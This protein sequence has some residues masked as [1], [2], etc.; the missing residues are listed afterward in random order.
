[1]HI[2]KFPNKLKNHMHLL[3][4]LFTLL[5]L[6]LIP[7]SS[8]SDEVRVA[9]LIGNNSYTSTPLINAVNDVEAMEKQLNLFEFHVTRATDLSKT[10][11]GKAIIHF[12]QNREPGSIGL[13]YYAGHS[14]VK[15]D[16]TYLAPI[17]VNTTD[18]KSIPHNS[19]PLTY[20]T[21][22]LSQDNNSKNIIIID[23]CR[24]NLDL[25][26]T[27]KNVHKYPLPTQI[28][29]NNIIVFSTSIGA[30]AYDGGNGNSPY[31]KA[32]LSITPHKAE[33]ILQLLKRVNYYVTQI[34]SGEQIPQ[35]YHN[36]QFNFYMKNNFEGTGET[37]NIL[38]AQINRKN[39]SPGLSRGIRIEP[40]PKEIKNTDSSDVIKAEPDKKKI[41][42]PTDKKNPVEKNTSIK[43]E[44]KINPPPEKNEPAKSV[45]SNPVV[46]SINGQRDKM[47]NG[48]LGPVIIEIKTGS[49]KMGG[50]LF[51]E[52]P[53]H[54]V[55]INQPI[56]FMTN[57][58]TFEEYDEFCNATKRNKPDDEFWGRSNR[59]VINV[60]WE[61]AQD[62][63][64]WLSAQT[65]AT[66]RLPLE[67]EWEWAAR[68]GSVNKYTW[69]QLFENN[70]AN[71]KTCGS[72]W[73]NTMTSPVGSFAPNPF[74]LYDMAGNVWEW[75]QDCW[76]E[77]YIN[78]PVHQIPRDFTGRCGNRTIRGGGWNSSPSQVTV[79]ARLGIM[80]STKSSFIGFRLVKDINNTFT[81]PPTNKPKK[82]TTKKPTVNSDIKFEDKP[83]LKEKPYSSG[84][85]Y[86]Y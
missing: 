51:S 46:E 58:V 32:F 77:N 30:P 20:L 74:G 25:T 45:T 80:T 52:K 16:E 12:S 59:P 69:G 35:I 39:F 26:P 63:A 85:E 33:N 17:N 6:F 76:A 86:R 43:E 60:D 73:D 10:E 82:I 81:P 47:S 28:L 50:Q 7:T 67:S 83:I 18:A 72:K 48:S 78:A 31:I 36:S 71:C 5:V 65:G 44:L 68:S 15:N 79:S 9:L 66:Y 84:N 2:S 11:M 70:K 54:T 53:I 24:Q 34:T 40:V 61:D 41:K 19:I 49:F 55:N 38:L 64:H 29:N 4:L 8:F 22:M 62:Y 23:S 21:K 56:F 42:L 1:M 75:V 14:F 13:F 37:S 3:K 27:Q 57:E